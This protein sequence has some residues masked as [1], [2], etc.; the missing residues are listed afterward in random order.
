MGPKTPENDPFNIVSV[1]NLTVS[2]KRS[3]ENVT[4][5]EEQPTISEVRPDFQEYSKS[6]R[7]INF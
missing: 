5:L 6:S 3:S 4:H 1:G 7:G 2:E